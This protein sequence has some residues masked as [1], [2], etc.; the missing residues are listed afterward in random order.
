MEERRKERKKGLTDQ[1][2]AAV[3]VGLDIRRR[4]LMCESQVGVT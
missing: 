3:A 1:L 2:A 4:S